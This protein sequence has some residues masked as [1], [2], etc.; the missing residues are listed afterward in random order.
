[1]DDRLYDHELDGLPATTPSVRGP[2]KGGGGPGRGAPAKAKPLPSG[3]PGRFLAWL[4]GRSLPG[5]IAF[6]GLAGLVTSSPVLLLAL[7]PSPLSLAL[8]LGPPLAAWLLWRSWARTPRP[9]AVVMPFARP[10][11]VSGL[12]VVLTAL[13]LVVFDV[14]GA[15]LKLGRPGLTY[16]LSAAA[17]AAVAAAAF[18]GLVALVGLR[19]ASAFAAVATFWVGLT[20][21]F[22]APLVLHAV[23]GMSSLDPELARDALGCAGF[24]GSA[25][26]FVASFGLTWGEEVLARE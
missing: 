18:L 23:E 6:G 24:T 5:L 21:F 10:W 8:I 14:Y 7:R 17:L 3:T 26:L 9:G 13:T 22:V 15:S 19:W 2:V 12:Y 16:G 4:N 25:A 20:H 1:V 11:A